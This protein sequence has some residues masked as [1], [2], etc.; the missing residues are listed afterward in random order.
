VDGLRQDVG[1]ALL[2]GGQVEKG[3]GLSANL[4]AG[5]SWRMHGRL[6]HPIARPATC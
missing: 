4:H 6:C 5:Q 2:N 1:C 3:L